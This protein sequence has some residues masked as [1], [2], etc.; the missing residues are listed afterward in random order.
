MNSVAGTARVNK[1]GV[2]AMREMAKKSWERPSEKRQAFAIIAKALT[3]YRGEVLPT[4]KKLGWVKCKTCSKQVSALRENIVPVD[5]NRPFETVIVCQRCLKKHKAK[6]MTGGMVAR[7]QAAQR[8]ENDPKKI[9]EKA[10][11][12]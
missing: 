3:A 7:I 1:Y 2:E 5:W 11:C 8:T 9:V 10:L 6:R 4:L 12:S